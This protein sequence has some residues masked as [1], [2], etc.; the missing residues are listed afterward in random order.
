MDLKQYFRKIRE[1]EASLLEEYPVLVSLETPDGGKAGT[2]CE[3]SRMNAA[4]MIAEGRAVLASPQQV[5]EF[6]AQQVSAR[7]AAEQ[8]EM[9][10]RI[11][12]AIIPEG[13]FGIAGKRGSLPP[14]G[15]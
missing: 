8:A 5:E 15:K 9:A 6:R 11:Q 14:S 10:K 3:T 12:V 1:I 4:R 2:F 7:K 13:E